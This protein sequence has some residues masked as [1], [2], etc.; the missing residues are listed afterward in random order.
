[1]NGH[2]QPHELWAVARENT[3]PRAAALGTASRTRPKRGLQRCGRTCAFSMAIS[4]EF[5][6]PSL[7][8]MMFSGQNPVNPN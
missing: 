8:K 5:F 4:T 2:I 1:M 3:S 6:T 7:R